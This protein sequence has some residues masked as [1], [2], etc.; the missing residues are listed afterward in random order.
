MKKALSVSIGSS[1][2]DKSVFIKLLG[3]D[4]H[5]QRIGTNGNMNAA[6]EMYREQDGKVDAFGVGG[7]DLGLLVDKKWYPLHSVLPLATGAGC[8]SN[9]RRRWLRIEE[10]RRNTIRT[11]FGYEDWRLP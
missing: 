10:H 4:V 11:H 5:I 6:R 2:R 8:T 1:K 3:Q 9:T 7:T